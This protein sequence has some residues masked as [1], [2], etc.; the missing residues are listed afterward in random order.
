MK[1][2]IQTAQNKRSGGVIGVQQLM[3]IDEQCYLCLVRAP[4][5]ARSLFWTNKPHFLIN[6]FIPVQEVWLVSRFRCAPP[7]GGVTA[8]VSQSFSAVWFLSIYQSYWMF[9]EHF[10]IDYTVS[11]KEKRVSTVQMYK[12]PRSLE[13]LGAGWNSSELNSRCV[14]IN[15]TKYKRWLHQ[16]Y[17]FNTKC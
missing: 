11:K 9:L 6:S 7:P 3:F 1:I 10:S 15:R 12:I 16:P 2:H 17:E 13:V 14:Y 5:L 8:C 4:D